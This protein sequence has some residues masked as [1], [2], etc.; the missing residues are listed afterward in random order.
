MFGINDKSGTSRIGHVKER[1][2]GVEYFF[3]DEVLMLSARDM[4][5]I[6][7]QLAKVFDCAHIPFSH[8][9][10]VFSGRAPR[11]G[12]VRFFGLIGLEPQPDRFKFFIY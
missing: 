7:L 3:F 9:N 8:L 11:S 2:A 5:H 12:P 6:H 1:M 4:Y 10:M